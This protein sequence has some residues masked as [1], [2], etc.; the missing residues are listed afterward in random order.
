[1]T[2]FKPL[3]LRVR[4]RSEEPAYGL[5]NRLAVRHNCE[6]AY[7]LATQFFGYHKNFTQAVGCGRSLAELA[8]VS[9]IPEKAIRNST[10]LVDKNEHVVLGGRIIS[11][12]GTISSTASFGR[13][14]S[15]CLRDDIESGQG[16]IECRPWRRTWW[17]IAGISSCPN[18]KAALL[19]GCPSCGMTFR[20]TTLS[21][22]YC[23][24][25][26]DLVEHTPEQLNGSET[27][28][29]R[30]LLGRLGYLRQ[31]PNNFLDLFVIDD[32]ATIMLHLGRAKMWGRKPP[33]LVRHNKMS[34][35]A[36][37]RAAS[38]GL[39]VCD[40]W[41]TGFTALLDEL[42]SLP[43]GKKVGLIS[44][45]GQL[46]RWLYLGEATAYEPLREVLQQHAARNVPMTS[47]AVVFRQPVNES[48]WI[49]LGAAGKIYGL[50]VERMGSI[51]IR[52][53]AL[54]GGPL[55]RSRVISRKDAEEIGEKLQYCVETQ[56][57]CSIL[58]VNEDM[59]KR[60]VKSGTVCRVWQNISTNRNFFDKRELEKLVRHLQGDVAE[61][62]KCPDG[63]AD[64]ISAA[65]LSGRK[66]ELVL[67]AL[68]NRQI[69]PVGRLSGRFG[70]SAI[71]VR[72]QELYQFGPK[73]DKTS[74]CITDASRALHLLDVRSLT[75]L[76]KAG[77]IKATRAQGRRKIEIRID[78][79]EIS[80]FNNT[81]V[82]AAGLSNMLNGSVTSKRVTKILT[83][84]Q[85]VPVFARPRCVWIFS[86]KQAEQALASLISS[87]SS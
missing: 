13:V 17:D 35:S 68:R 20:R 45:Y 78:R 64:I 50:S 16:P 43:T 69:S 25:G 75:V 26:Y 48:E 21:P 28:A 65:H 63:C 55:V 5:L 51:A 40:R 82:T 23:E 86:R 18:H 39:Q 24:C 85:I 6:S 12:T 9:G 53:G 41:P 22:R 15:E 1:M 84:L 29:D 56:E 83:K 11:K 80:R 52:T 34:I 57:A 60:L 37:A 62:T 3:P 44:F 76:V 58:G 71:V 8:R 81:F 46:Y 27:K 73:E 14:C 38:T 7:D 66:T 42:A 87:S 30:Y 33:S 67:D 59:F 49:T 61:I 74:L 47:T 10:M 77:I 31:I 54:D 4:P 32:A 79:E 2:L 19:E 72:F 36:R 70:L